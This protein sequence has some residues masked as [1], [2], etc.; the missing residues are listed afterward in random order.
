MAAIGSPAKGEEFEYSDGSRVFAAYVS[1]AGSEPVPTVLLCHEWSGL[2][3]GM[4]RIADRI[5]ALGYVCF[6][7]DVYGKGIRG[8]ETGDN[9]HL[10]G[11]L[12]ANRQVLRDRLLTGLVAAQTYPG[13]DPQRLAAMGY[14]FGGLC[15]LDLARAAPPALRAAISIHGVL[16][17]PHIRPQ[18]PITASV[19][20]EH[21]WEDPMAPQSDVLALARELTDA[22][23]DW[24]I[25][26]HGHAF[27]AF[28]FEGANMPE[29]GIVYNATADR[30]SW[31]S[32]ES[33]LNETL[34]R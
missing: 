7:L 30:R 27:H 18:L 21:G 20:I 2:N 34:R 19:L 13:V 10:M 5:A 29:R 17:P 11:P 26:A 14:C 8:E 9:A 22:G 4:R 1:G 33:F 28:T 32:V 31:N 12:M 6:A 15:S 23:A 16:T 3:Q 24:Q 25:H